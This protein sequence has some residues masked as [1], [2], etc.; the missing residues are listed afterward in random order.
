MRLFILPVCISS[1]TALRTHYVK[2]YSHEAIRVT[3]T[4]FQQTA[5]CLSLIIESRLNL[6]P[7]LRKVKRKRVLRVKTLLSLLQTAGFNSNLVRNGTA[8]I[9]IPLVN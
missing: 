4:C 9:S 5:S 8:L 2:W 7:K 1:V 3:V 6:V